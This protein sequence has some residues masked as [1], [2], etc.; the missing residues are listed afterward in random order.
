MK[1][2]YSAQEKAVEHHLSFLQQGKSVL[3][4]SPTGTGKTVVAAHTIARL[5]CPVFVVCPRIVIPQWKAELKDA[6]VDNYLGVLNYEMLRRGGTPF[7]TKTRK[8][9]FTWHLP[10]GTV[11]IWDEV[12][13]CKGAD[14]QN[15]CMLITATKQGYRSMMLSATACKDATEMRGIGYALGLHQ[16]AKQPSWVK[17]MKDHGCWRDQY[18]KWRPGSPK[19]LAPL[20][21]KLLGNG[22]HRTLRSDLPG[23]FRKNQI[24]VDPIRF[25]G[26]SSIRKWYAD[27]GITNDVVELFLDEE[28]KVELANLE[29]IVLLLRE[30][31][32]VEVAKAPDIAEMCRDIVSEG[33]SAVVFVNFIE[34][35]DVIMEHLDGLD[36][37]VVLGGQS[38]TIRTE[39]VEA[40]QRDRTRVILAQIGAGGVGVN[41]HDVRG[42][43]PRTSLI[44]PTFSVIHYVQSL[45]RIDRAG[46]KSDAVQR[47][48]VAEG[49]VE[50]KL[51]SVLAQKAVSLST[52]L[53]HST[54]TL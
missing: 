22:M 42:E 39:N 40:F 50:E 33:R 28:R 47:V 52:V 24:I 20:R 32:V 34:T 9:D 43:F 38:E 53:A 44:S 1:T 3:N 19:H 10:E 36:C 45:G 6:G 25:R 30:R 2:L 31:Q 27:N 35:M 11:I 8:K 46:S 5:G 23:A 21:E 48:L 12:H 51:I 37:S 16:L 54:P 18:R 26:L 7:V 13:N 14:S 29:E 17:L 41:L 4:T 15:V 49:T